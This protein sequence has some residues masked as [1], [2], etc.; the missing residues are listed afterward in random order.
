MDNSID[1][2]T[3]HDQPHID[4]SDIDGGV[5][6]DSVLIDDA[7]VVGTR[8]LKEIYFN[9]LDKRW[10]AVDRAN[11]LGAWVS[12]GEYRIGDVVRYADAFYIAKSLRSGADTTA[13]EDDD[14]WLDITGA[15]GVAAGVNLIFT[16]TSLPAAASDSPV[17]V[18]VEEDGIY[19]RRS[20]TGIDTS[21]ITF[22]PSAANPFSVASGN[23]T[24]RTGLSADVR[25]YVESISA[26]YENTLSQDRTTYN[27]RRGHWVAYLSPEFTAGGITLTVGTTTI[28]LQR[29]AGTTRAYDGRTYTRYQSPDISN[30]ANS[31]TILTSP[32]KPRIRLPFNVTQY[33]YDKVAFGPTNANIDARIAAF[34]RTGATMQISRMRGLPAVLREPACRFRHRRA[35]AAS[36]QRRHRAGVCGCGSRGWVVVFQH[37]W[38]HCRQPVSSSSQLMLFFWDE[39]KYIYQKNE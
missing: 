23:F 27:F 9:E 30:Q 28:S 34:A 8:S 3:L 17:N 39:W 26:E 13:P 16:Y 10:A 2:T 14:E 22:V 15:G 32:Y 21:D 18:Y 31:A 38:M 19:H 6:Q 25:R 20:I 5:G 29:A 37:L 24:A 12:G 4:N 11:Y 35:G 36:E 7:S 33:T 1:A